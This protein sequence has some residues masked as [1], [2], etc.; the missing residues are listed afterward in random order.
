VFDWR[1]TEGQLVENLGQS[2]EW[3]ADA[4][5]IEPLWARV[6]RGMAEVE[7]ADVA[8]LDAAPAEW[9]ELLATIDHLEN[10]I[11]FATFATP[12]A[13][14]DMRE[15]CLRWRVTLQRRIAEAEGRS[16]GTCSDPYDLAEIDILTRSLSNARDLLDLRL[17]SF[18]GRRFTHT[19]PPTASELRRLSEIEDI[20]GDW[21]GLRADLRRAYHA[22]GIPEDEWAVAPHGADDRELDFDR[23]AMV[24]LFTS[25]AVFNHATPRWAS[26][27]F[28]DTV[29]P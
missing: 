29:I 4:P 13:Q 22:A 27:L 1:T 26:H 7:R 10:L 5:E 12:R 6:E 15:Q 25:I 24:D 3:A 18:A 2:L 9:V 16:G 28:A 21:T 17:V 14:I 19:S 20:A 23:Q 8:R 11:D